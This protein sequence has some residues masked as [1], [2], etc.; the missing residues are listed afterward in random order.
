M[1]CTYAGGGV[2]S[3]HA[4]RRGQVSS[5]FCKRTNWTT[6]Y[7]YLRG[8]Y[9]DEDP[10]LLP[11]RE[12]VGVTIRGNQLKLKKRE[13][14]GIQRANFFSF[15]VVNMWNSLQEGVVMSSSVS[16][17]KGCFD[18]FCNEL[19]FSKLTDLNEKYASLRRC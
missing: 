1:K 19:R 17:F 7:K 14:R 15:R 18:R 16:I 5:D 8:I 2:E 11:L 13:C 4:Y 12:S 9:T 3:T 10:A 6:P